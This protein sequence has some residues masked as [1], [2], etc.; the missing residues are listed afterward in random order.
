MDLRLDRRALL[1]GSSAGAG[2]LS[3]GG[4]GLWAKSEHGGI[5]TVPKGEAFPK[6]QIGMNLSGI[7]DWESGFPFRN[8]FWGARPWLTR[9]ISGRGPHD[10][11]S[12]EF[13]ELDADGYPLEVPFAAPGRAEPQTV[14]TYVPNVAKPGRYTLLYDGEGELGGLVST[15]IVSSKPGRIVLQMAH[16][17]AG[18][19]EA[20]EIKRSVRGNHVRNIRLV[21]QSD[22]D[23]DLSVNP[24]LPDFIEFCRPFRCLRFMEWGA[25]NNS[26]QEHWSDRK[27]PTFYTMRALTGDPEARWGPGPT[28]FERRFAGGVAYEVMIQLCNLLNADMWLCIPHRATDDHILEVARLVRSTL[29]PGLKVYLEYSNEIW[30]WQ[31]YQAGWMLHSPVAGALVEAKGGFPW[32]DSA[33]VEGKDHPERI[34]A[35]FRRAFSIWEREW[36]SEPERLIRVCAVQAAWADASKRTIRWC[37]ENGGVDAVS[38]AAYVGPDETAYMNWAAA[39]E[40]LTADEVIDDLERVLLNTRSDGGLI[41]TL[42]FARDRGLAY[43]AYEGGQHIQPKDQKE[44]PYNSALSAAQTHPRM[45]DLYIELLRLHRDLGCEMFCH[46]S[47]VS[48]QGSRFG[49]WGAKARYDVPDQA[50]PKMRALLDCNIY[51][52]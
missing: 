43:V 49:S 35:L 22:E 18:S 26:V 11:K 40:K 23:I 27:R 28:G 36:S 5:G 51:N 32:K 25:T 20:I 37:L 46:Y 8:L 15:K 38:P 6:L 9:N 1:F 14:F 48:S 17:G 4:I 31:F 12:Q 13:L 52:S 34:G 47:S 10:T 2:I 16:L 29:A 42:A 24:F 39:G 45:Y 44:L 19:H 41:E 3:F 30:N 50:S 33:K 7:S 21:A